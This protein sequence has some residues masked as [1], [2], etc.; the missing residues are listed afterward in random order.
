MVKSL[1]K[2]R[3]KQKKKRNNNQVNGCFYY[4]FLLCYV[5][6]IFPKKN[7]NKKKTA[8]KKNNKQFFLFF[9]CLSLCGWLGWMDGWLERC[10]QITIKCR[11][12]ENNFF[13]VIRDVEFKR[14]NNKEKRI[15][16]NFNL[17]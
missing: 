7:T 12:N 1:Q 4:K 5:S 13:L 8:S 11:V 10:N 16:K 17:H 6:I 14:N 2:K 3:P 9:F 15:K